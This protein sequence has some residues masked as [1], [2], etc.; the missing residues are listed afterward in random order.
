M[1]LARFLPAISGAVPWAASKSAT[2]TTRRR[3]EGQVGAGT[4]AQRAGQAA[5]HVREE[6][7]VF[8]QDQ[9][10]LELL[11]H[12]DD[13]AQ[14]RVEELDGVGHLGELAGDFLGDLL[15]Q[16]VGRLL[17]RVF[18]GARDPFAGLAGKVE[19]V[20]GR[21]AD[22]PPLDDS[23]ADRAVLADHSAGIVVGPAGGDP[24]DVEIELAAKIRR[25]AG[26]R[27]DRPMD[28]RKLEP[29]PQDRVGAL[30]GR[31]R[32]ML[33]R[34]PGGGDRLDRLVV[35]ALPRALRFSSRKSTS[36]KSSRIGN[37]SA[38]RWTARDSSW[39][40]PSPRSSVTG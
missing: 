30:L 26:N 13:L 6:I 9:H 34:N 37:A 2:R 33:E 20:P 8:V 5:G 7:A 14:E 11:G 18:G 1:G 22:R 29:P 36:T 24:H 17:D 10:D 39:P 16:A 3:V 35:D 27:V 38:S 23:Q 19:C 40:I 21:L 31:G 4:D 28:D 12:H 15:K 25:H 32:R